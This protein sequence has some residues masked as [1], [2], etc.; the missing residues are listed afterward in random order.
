MPVPG[1]GSLVLA[2][3]HSPKERLWA[4][5]QGYDA[6]GVWLEG[7]D[8]Q[9]FDDWARQIGRGQEPSLGLS[10]IFY[11]LLRVEKLLLDRSAPGQPSCAER[12][13]VLVGTDVEEY[14]GLTGAE[15]GE[16]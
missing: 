3:L 15:E 13:R 2:F 4:V 5:L 7:I 16:R 10:L 9:S 1:P 14:L 11:P 8:V 12:F 6:A